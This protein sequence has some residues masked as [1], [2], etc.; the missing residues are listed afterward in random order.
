MSKLRQ[1]PLAR[2]QT[3]G[4]I[5]TNNIPSMPRLSKHVE[6]VLLVFDSYIENSLKEGE[7]KRRANETKGIEIIGMT[8]DTPVPK[9]PDKFWASEDKRNIQ[10][11]CR[12][13]VRNNVADNPAI[14]TSSAVSDGEVLPAQM[15]VGKEI[16][17]ILSWIEEADAR[18]I[19]Q[20][21]WVIRVNK[22]ERII[23]I[24]NDTGTFALLLHYTPYFQTLGAREIWQEYGTGE[25][26]KKTSTTS[27]CLCT[28]CFPSKDSNEGTYTIW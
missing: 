19:V 10:L 1:M 27:G 5:I 15:T 26:K 28:R 17:E 21:E 24:S 20:V 6:C 13:I 14:I 7:R 16:P 9:R 8:K 23:I 2:F 11:L 18:L 3:P 25:K 22:C 4:N 12:D